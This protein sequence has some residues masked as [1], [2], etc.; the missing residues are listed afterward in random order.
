M[1]AKWI[2]LI[3]V[4]LAC[5]LLVSCG[6]GSGGQSQT[7]SYKDTKSMVLD[8]LKTEDGQKAIKEASEKNKD[9]TAKLLS[10]GEGVQIQTAVKDVLTDPSNSKLIEKT[11]TDPKFAGDFAK[12]IQKS[13]KD[14]H[15][16]L[17]K[18]PEYQKS[19]LELM[20]STDYEK[21]LLSVMKSPQ[22]RQQV[23]TVME[24]SLKSPLFKAQL[25]E[26]F[27]K[28]AQDEMKPSEEDM[29][30][31]SSDEKG[32]SKGKSDEKSKEKDKKQDS[33]SQDKQEQ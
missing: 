33:S 13:N 31:K 23:M 7:Q 10:S 1:S 6:S 9:K 12:A 27:K 14:L 11:M 32:K 21:M 4:L 8:V 26:L 29:K 17:M 5:L 2:R 16:D 15:K 25:M 30:A 28:V 3:P 19:M 24:E 20:N 18:D 22:Y